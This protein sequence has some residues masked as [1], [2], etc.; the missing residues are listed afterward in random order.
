MYVF[1][2]A[3]FMKHLVHVIFSKLVRGKQ[4]ALW[5]YTIV[6]HGSTLIKNNHEY[7]LMVVSRTYTYITVYSLEYLKI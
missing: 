7:Y 3:V 2:V 5:K 4:G 1:L 6:S